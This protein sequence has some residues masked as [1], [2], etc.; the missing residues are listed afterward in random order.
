[1]TA[2]QENAITLA[3]CGATMVGLYWAGAGGHS[4]WA[5]LFLL[6]LLW[7][8]GGENDESPATR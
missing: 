3:L 5:L 2:S 8:D 4:F 7:P 1:M 6:N